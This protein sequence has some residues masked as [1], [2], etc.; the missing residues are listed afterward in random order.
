MINQ[1]TATRL[2]T[3]SIRFPGIIDMAVTIGV[4]IIMLVILHGFPIRVDASMP[5]QIFLPCRC[6]SQNSWAA[7]AIGRIPSIMIDIIRGS[8]IM[9]APILTPSRK[10]LITSKAARIPMMMPMKKPTTMVSP[11]T[12][13]LF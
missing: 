13:N 9:T 7:L 4:M 2:A 1:G 11:K 3:A 6:F 5:I 12:P 10:H 8:K